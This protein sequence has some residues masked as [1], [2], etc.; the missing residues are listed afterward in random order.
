MSEWLELMLAEIERKRDET[1]RARAE[2][3]A[4]EREASS[5]ATSASLPAR[6][7]S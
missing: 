7:P 6:A 4:R 3:D 1:V 2:H 5:A